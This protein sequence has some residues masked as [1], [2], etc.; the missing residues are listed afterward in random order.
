[1][2]SISSIDICLTFYLIRR[3]WTLLQTEQYQIRQLLYELYDQG[4][5]SMLM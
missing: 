1:M 3:L 2:I 4:L 5:L